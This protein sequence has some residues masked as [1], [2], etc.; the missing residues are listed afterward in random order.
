MMIK[1]YIIASFL[2]FSVCATCQETSQINKTDQQGKKTGHWIKRYPNESVMYDGYFKDDHPVGEFK[3]FY[4]DQ[5]LK[6]L[7]IYS[8]DGRKA[9]ATIY[10]Q[11]G[12]LSSKGTYVDQLKEGKW[13]FFSEIIN[14]YL[15]SEE[16]YSKNRRNGPSYKFYPDSSIAERLSYIND[17]KQGEWI[18]YYSTGAVHLKTNY[19]DGKIN[20]RFEVWFENGAPEYSGQYDN[21]KRDGL[22]TIYKEDGSVKYKLLYVKGVTN[23]KQLE[24]DESAFLDS[25]ENNKGKIADPE[26]TGIIK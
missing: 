25:L 18:Q 12:Y 10:H 16:N 20:G 3:R 26:K 7:L 4:E 21:D 2:A 8:D 23:D 9:R 24:D 19:L 5:T 22:W 11:N 13:Q 6:S 15:I 17:I 14:G 1:L